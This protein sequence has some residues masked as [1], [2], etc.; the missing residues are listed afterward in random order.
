MG[1]QKRPSCEKSRC[2]KSC[3]EKSDLLRKVVL[4]KVVH[5]FAK[6][7]KSRSVAKSRVA[8]SPVTDMGLDIRY[9]DISTC[10]RMYTTQG[11]EWNGGSPHYDPTAPP[12]YIKFIS[13]K[14]EELFLLKQKHIYFKRERCSQ[15]NK[16]DNPHQ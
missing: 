4:R 5:D 7:A 10:H 9:S 12:I 6:V 8:K 3:C 1:L 2:E 15:Q 16:K 13:H 11:S 14:K